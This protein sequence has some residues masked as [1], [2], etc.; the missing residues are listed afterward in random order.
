MTPAL[1]FALDCP[2]NKNLSRTVEYSSLPR[3][4]SK[5]PTKPALQS[6]EHT[7]LAAATVHTIN[8]LLAVSCKHA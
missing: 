7:N 4:F 1:L 8:Q 5:V 2:S 6:D 3:G